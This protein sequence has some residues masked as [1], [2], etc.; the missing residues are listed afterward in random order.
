MAEVS[1]LRFL[2]PSGQFYL[3][4]SGLNLWLNFL[5]DYLEAVEGYLKDESFSVRDRY[6]EFRR[7][8][9]SFNFFISEDD[10]E[11]TRALCENLMRG[12]LFVA[13]YSFA[14]TELNRWCEHIT[15]SRPD[16]LLKLKDISA[17]DRSISKAEKYLRAVAGADL[18]NLGEWEEWGK[19]KQYQNLRNRVVHNQACLKPDDPRT[20]KSDDLRKYVMQHS[21]LSIGEGE[22]PYG[23]D[24]VI[25]HKGFCEEVARLVRV[26][27]MRMSY[28]VFGDGGVTHQ[29]RW[30]VVND[31]GRRQ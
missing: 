7:Q 5:E 21:Y 6:Q 26:V 24:L 15:K 20:G 12:S 2:G 8:F 13:A 11:Q 23:E 16:I 9:D 25:F 3:M 4:V 29:R 30:K 31:K 22:G 17:K 18:P 27:L 19:L 28:C 1:Y 14:E 10:L